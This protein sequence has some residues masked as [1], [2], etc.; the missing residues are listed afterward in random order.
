MCARACFLKESIAGRIVEPG[1]VGRAAIARVQSESF[2]RE[3]FGGEGAGIGDPT[4]RGSDRVA[5]L[6]P[7]LKVLDLVDAL[8][9]LDPLDDLRHGDKVDVIVLANDFVHPKEEGVHEFGI[10]LEPSGVEEETERSAVLSVVPV[11]VVVQE[12]VELLARQNVGARVNHGAAGQVLVEFGIFTTI[13]LVHDQLPDGVAPSGALLKVAVAAVRH[14][15]V[16]GVRPERRVL[17]RS[18]DGRVVQEGLLFHHGELVV[19]ADAKVRGA[20]AD[21][22]VVGDVGELVDDEAS[23]GHFLGPVVHRCRRP[24]ALLIVMPVRRLKMSDLSATGRDG[25]KLLKL[26]MFLLFL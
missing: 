15:E 1:V 6:L 22:R 10:V 18:S 21:D 9:V 4:G 17:Q 2:T 24:E 5:F 11:K 12:S 16:E 7:R 19:A 20:H 25:H 23:A 3:L 8:G 26:K 14:A 13:Q